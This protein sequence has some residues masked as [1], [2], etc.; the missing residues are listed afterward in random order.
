MRRWF[1]G[2]AGGSEAKPGDAGAEPAAAAES[3][4]GSGAGGS[5]PANE[6]EQ[7]DQARDEYIAQAIQRG[8]AEGVAQAVSRIQAGPAAP[9]AAPPTAGRGVVAELEAEAAAINAETQRIEQAF[10]ADGY[11]A[12]NLAD[13]NKLAMRVSNFNARLL[14][15][16]MSMQETERHV[17]GAAQ[18]DDKAKAAAWRKYAQDNMGVP[19]RFLRPAFEKE[20]AE[21]NPQP[22]TKPKPVAT[23]AARN[24]NVSGA[25]EVSAREAKLRSVTRAEYD[26]EMADAEDRGDHA[27]VSQLGRDV[28]AG[29]LLVKG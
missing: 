20:Y 29:R 17:D 25:S 8:I 7:A 4:S 16:G 1:E 27:K 18:G 2:G 5:E 22:A 15:Q 28:R 12:K 10:V 21:A 6:R 26:R 3:A 13:Q 9:A 14:A 19:V 23:D 11:T 24:T